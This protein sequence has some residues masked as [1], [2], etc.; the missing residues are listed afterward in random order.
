VDANVVVDQ[1]GGC[2]WRVALRGEHDVATAPEVEAALAD[3]A[4]RGADVI[5]DLSEATFADSSI[6]QAILRY[7]T[8]PGESFVIVALPETLPHHLLDLTAVAQLVPVC[9]SRDDA[10]GQLA[11]AKPHHLSVGRGSA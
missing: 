8:A 4:Q 11:R 9:D 2:G 6:L 1:W 5:I 3:I 7:A 10:L